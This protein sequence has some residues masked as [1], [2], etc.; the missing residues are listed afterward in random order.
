MTQKNWTHTDVRPFPSHA[1]KQ[2]ANRSSWLSQIECSA[3]SMVDLLRQRALRRPDRTIYTFLTDGEEIGSSLTYSQLDTQARAIAATLQEFCKPGDRALLVFPPGLEYVSAF[4]GCLYAGVLAVPVYP[5]DPSRLKRTLPRFRVIVDDA[6]P[7][8]ALTCAALLNMEQALAH[9]DPSLS[10]LRWIASDKVNP[11]LA[12]AWE[13]PTIMPDHIAFL[14]YTS[15]STANPKGVMVSNGNLLFNL[16]DMSRY[17]DDTEENC[18][19]TW[20]PTYHDMGLIHSLLHPLYKDYPCYSM[21]PMAFLQR[22]Y[23]WLRAIS[24]FRA[25]TSVAPNFAYD[26]CVRKIT[27]EQRD[28]LDLSSW[29]SAGN[30]A[31]PVR[32]E[33]LERFYNTFKQCGFRWRAITPGYGLAEATLE[34]SQTSHEEGPTFLPIKSD[35]LERHRAVEAQKPGPGVRVLV[36]CGRPS[37]DTRVII[38][39]PE[40]CLQCTPD[41]V[42]EIWVAGPTVAQGYWRRAEDTRETFQACLADSGEG[43]FLRTGDLGFMKDGYLFVTGRIKDMIII[44]GF[45]HYPQ[46]IER[47]VELSHSAVRPGCCAAFSIEEGGQERLIVVSEVAETVQRDV[48]ASAD[49]GQTQGMVEPKEVITAIRRAV[50]ECHDLRVFKVCL[51]EPRSIHKTTSGKIQRQACRSAFLDGV[52]RVVACE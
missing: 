42:G 39:D 20:L 37:K 22:P 3:V 21:S 25:T 13:D 1:D 49:S 7:S 40:S 31:E 50:S 41:T 10:T 9:A 12:E 18:L 28:V 16:H 35:E 45:N 52:H 2:T 36:S 29:R 11:K 43:P 23:R 24:K 32:P 8:V 51:I 27:P 14:Q 30:G 44:D 34:V 19:V 47:T 6:Q 38:V 15:G 4:F 46:D 26:L 17:F 5:P 48:S 33:T